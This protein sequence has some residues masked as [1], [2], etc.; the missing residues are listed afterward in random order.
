MSESNGTTDSKS[1]GVGL[2]TVIEY[3]TQSGVLIYVTPLSLFTIQAIVNKSEVE[4]PYPS[5]V[6]YREPSELFAS[7]FL[8][9]SENPEYQALC[10]AVDEQRLTWQND[11][12][13]ELACAY[14]QFENHLAMMVHFRPRLEEL[15]PYVQ[16]DA[17]EWKNVLEHCV[18]TGTLDVLDENG[19]R[20]RT[21]E[22]FRVI[23]LARQNANV[24]LTMSEVVG[25][26]RVFRLSVP[27]NDTRG[28]DGNGA[29][30]VE[31]RN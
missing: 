14:P 11:A 4:Y 8:P 19:K 22:R 24:A 7:G 28:M 29:R 13:I 30:R 21:T 10:K 2:P 26:L 6:D 17:D 15:R 16:L 31:K 5:E 12:F 1:D 9:A 20:V 18:F 3:E 25:G 23:Q 27:G